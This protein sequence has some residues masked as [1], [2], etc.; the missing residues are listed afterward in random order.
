MS[1][2]KFFVSKGR[3]AT[4]LPRT[5]TNEAWCLI[6]VPDGS[7][8]FTSKS[9]VIARFIYVIKPLRNLYKLPPA[10]ISIFFDLQGDSIAFNRNGSIF[11]N[12]RYFESWRQYCLN[13]FNTLNTYKATR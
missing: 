12:L 8:I 3:D 7:I 9:E 10:S 13:M 4:L 1:D 2:V 11:L 5:A 6:E